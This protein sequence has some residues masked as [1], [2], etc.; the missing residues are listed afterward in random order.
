MRILSNFN[1]YYDGVQKSF[2]GEE[3]PKIFLRKS[4]DDRVKI[5]LPCRRYVHGFRLGIIGF[6]G[7]LYPFFVYEVKGHP[8]YIPT[9]FLSLSNHY[10]LTYDYDEIFQYMDNHKKCCYFFNGASKSQVFNDVFDL[11]HSKKL[12]D[13]FVEQSTP[14]FSVSLAE[15][16]EDATGYKETS[17][18]IDTNPCLKDFKFQTLFDPFTAYQEI[19]MF[20]NNELVNDESGKQITDNVILRDAKGFD[21][22]SF[23]TLPNKRKK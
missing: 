18:E 15:Y 11:T 13:V 7:K 1:D 12:L 3:N 2:V 14:V 10:K 20:L 16:D 17:W 9:G 21:S 19:D 6:C 23:K 22:W 8:G 4:K 5:K